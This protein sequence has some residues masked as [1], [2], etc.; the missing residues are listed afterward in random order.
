MKV[1]IQLGCAV[2]FALCS[3]GCGAKQ[4]EGTGPKPDE[5]Q[6]DAGAA[7]PSVVSAENRIRNWLGTELSAKVGALAKELGSNLGSALTNDGNV[8]QQSKKLTDAILKD[9][10]VKKRLDQ[11]RDRATKGFTNKLTLGWKVI[12]AGGVDAFKRKVKEDTQK[13]AVPVLVDYIQNNVLKDKRTGALL[14]DFGP[15]LKVQA[16][17]AALG[18]EENLSARVTKKILGVALR[19]SAAG[20]QAD[21][22]LRVE[23]WIQNCQG[24][25]NTEVEKF[26]LGVGRLDSLTLAIRGLAADVLGHETTKRELTVMMKNLLADQAVDGA[27]VKVY[28]AA[29]FEKGETKVRTALQAVLSLPATDRELFAALQRLASAPGAN[30]MINKHA[31]LVSQDPQLAQLIE[32]FVLNLLESCGDPTAG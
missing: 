15:A 24:T 27:L 30:A 32:E 7:D 6:P 25:A 29:T 10:E 11:I 3:I 2:L 21:M 17:I 4:P 26:M 28:N 1:S 8:K 22:A 19:I 16:K 13:V 20:D 5:A 31:S 14:K 12:K 18:V 9:A 23:K